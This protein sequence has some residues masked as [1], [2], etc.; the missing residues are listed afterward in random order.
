MS[1]RTAAAIGYVCGHLAD[2]RE[3]LEALGD[4]GPLDRLLAAVR[5]GEEAAGPLD[6]LHEALVAGGDVL[7]VY[8]NA[9]RGLRPLSVGP[10]PGEFVFLCPRRR[11]VRY[12]WPSPESGAAPCCEI[13]GT[14]MTR[15]RLR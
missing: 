2:I 11:C 14:P 8:G 6:W 1:D 13:D 5:S 7:G 4:T 9:G 15:E 3:H 12:R 10:D